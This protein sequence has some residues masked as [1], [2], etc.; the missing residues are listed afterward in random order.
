M[1]RLATTRARTHL[2]T[3]LVQ[4]GN[5]GSPV[6]VVRFH[7]SSSARTDDTS[8]S[9]S[10]RV[11]GPQ[12]SGSDEHLASDK[13]S[14]NEVPS[15][16]SGAVGSGDIAASLAE[17]DAVI[18]DLKDR[19]LRA[20]AEME[21]VRAIAR[22][23]VAIARDFGITNFARSLLVVADNLSLALR[24]V[25]ED[26][27]RDDQVLASLHQGVEA[28]ENELQKVLAQH[29]VKRFGEVGEV[30]DPNRHQALFEA[31]SETAQPGTVLDITKVGY[32][33]GERILRPAEVGVVKA[34]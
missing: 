31:P 27:I 17:K 18:A 32:S 15:G 23:D 20:L 19:S 6:A 5:H 16:V 34:K 29:G 10:D 22:R 28:T 24:A 3:L 14:A 21:N 30:F 33:I 4:R 7:S 8:T 26:K 12:S 11:S 9:S 25:P 13:V 2:S 1:L